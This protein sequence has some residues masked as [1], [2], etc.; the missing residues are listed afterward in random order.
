[1]FKIMTRANTIVYKE[2]L[3]TEEDAKDYIENILEPR[4]MEDNTFVP[5]WYKILPM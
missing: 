2:N 3:P 5:N 1:M 4:D